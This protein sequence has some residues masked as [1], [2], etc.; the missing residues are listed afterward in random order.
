M[1]R[2]PYRQDSDFNPSVH[3]RPLLAAWKR[4][5]ETGQITADV[6]PPHIAESWKQSR[7]KGVDPFVCSRSARLDPGSFERRIADLQYLIY[8]AKPFMEKI[9]PSLDPRRYLVVLYD[10]EGYHLLRMGRVAAFERISGFHIEGGICFGE[11]KIGTCGFSL[12]K[13]LRR[14]VQIAG[15][16]HYAAFMHRI[17]GSYA[18]INDPVEGALMGVIG[19]AG[20]M[21]MP[22]QQ[23]LDTIAS[24]SAAIEDSI[25]QDHARRIFSVQG[26]TLQ[27]MIDHLDEG[28]ALI[29]REGRIAEINLAARTIFGLTGEDAKGRRLEDIL[30]AP[31]ARGLLSLA[32]GDSAGCDRPL[33]I[34]IRS[35]P[36]AVRGRPVRDPKEGDIGRMID[37]KAL[38]P[39]ARSAKRPAADQDPVKPPKE[40]HPP[41]NPVRETG[42]TKVFFDTMIASSSKMTELIGLG[43]MAARSGANI[44]I[45]G[46]SG[47]GKEIFAHAIHNESTRRDAPFVAIN[48]SAIP[49]ELMESILFGHEQGAFTGAHQTHI[50]KFEL[51]DGGT[52]FLDEIGE[53]PAA[54]QAKL[55]RVLE[56]KTIE[57]VGG[58]KVRRVDVRIVAAT[59]R[60]LLKEIHANRF[61]ED[62]YYRLNVFRIALPPLR[63]RKQ[64]IRHL[65][66]FFVR[67]FGPLFNKTVE[68]IQ[69][70]YYRCLMD[71]PWP[72]NIRE[73]RNAVEYSIA[74]L[75]GPV[76]AAEHV[77]G[78]FRQPS[79]DGN[80]PADRT[81][82]G[83]PLPGLLLS[84]LGDAA[85]R[86]ALSAADGHKTKAARMLGISRTTLHRRLKRMAV[87]GPPQ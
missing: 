61:R 49:G 41:R 6:I 10:A 71:Y 72:G 50:G 9:Y 64:E 7:A 55:L 19:I 63:E 38:P 26:R 1:M 3:Q 27:T 80:D 45:E 31:E 46:E 13:K 43:R 58:K 73:L 85:I 66:P 15:C 70:D 32:E 87:Q 37:L 52:V 59:N 28:I 75:N 39:S 54:M 67:Q 83:G 51:A 5:L 8:I 40:S 14:P 74:V 65:V 79:A 29:D 86:N 62:L 23:T 82:P 48:C 78:F 76:L 22:N 16:E 69:E 81:F 4:F 77:L 12:V 44:I 57:R 68:R 42:A 11:N 17:V 53:M 35:K 30:S 56:E 20:A 24:A 33:E 2:T 36:Y 60:N 25:K 47:T 21:T 34:S 84:E 18:P